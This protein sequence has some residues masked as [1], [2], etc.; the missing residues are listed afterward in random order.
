VWVALSYDRHVHHP[1]A[2]EWFEG[3]EPSVTFDA[4]LRKKAASVFLLKA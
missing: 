4:G 1:I 2:R 3:L